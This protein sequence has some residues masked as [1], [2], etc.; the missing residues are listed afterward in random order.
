[1]NQ[2]NRTRNFPIWWL[3]PLASD[4][5]RVDRII[6]WNA[7]LWRKIEN[8]MKNAKSQRIL[9]S[10]KNKPP[11]DYF[12]LEKTA[13]RN[14]FRLQMQWSSPN[15]SPLGIFSVWSPSHAVLH[16]CTI[17]RCV[18]LRIYSLLCNILPPKIE[19][20]HISLISLVMYHNWWSWFMHTFSPYESVPSKLCWF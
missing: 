18:G 2:T 3:V 14:D 1:M 20:D 17:T 7:E 6:S 19:S 16:R 15:S 5:W 13:H 10:T 12:Q 4:I 9:S 11:S 8:N